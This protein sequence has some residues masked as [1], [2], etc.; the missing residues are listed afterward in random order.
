MSEQLKKGR[1]EDRRARGEE[2]SLDTKA[3]RERRISQGK[4]ER[5]RAETVH[6][7]FSVSN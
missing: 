2:Q 5:T 6:V 4:D 1:K 7:H 3:L